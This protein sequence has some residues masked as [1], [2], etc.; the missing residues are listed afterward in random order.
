MMVS[1]RMSLKSARRAGF[2]LIELLVV[3]SIIAILVALLLPAVQAA[4]EAARSTQCKNNLRQFGIGLHAF[5]SKENTGRLCSGAWDGGRDGAL[6][7]YGWVADIIQVKAG[8][9][10]NMRCP[11]NP[12]LTTE[13]INDALA[14]DTS[15]SSTRPSARKDVFGKFSIIYENAT[16]DAAGVLIRSAAIKDMFE[17]GYNTNYAAGWHLVRSAPRLVTV[18]TG[19]TAVPVFVNYADSTGKYDG[20]AKAGFKEHTNTAGPLTQ[21]MMD[22]SNV[23]SS[24]IAILAD[25]ARGD[26]KEAVL[27][28]AIGTGEFQAGIP[29]AEAFNDGPSFWD[30]ATSKIKT[31][32]TNETVTNLSP[33][34][35]PNVGMN[36]SSAGFNWGQ[37]YEPISPAVVGVQP[38]FA[39]AACVAGSGMYLQDTRDWF[40]V[41]NGTC[42]LLMADGSVKQLQDRNNDGY[43]NPGF[44]VTTSSG[45]GITELK[46]QA[47]YI[48]GT[49]EINSFEVFTGVFLN[50]GANPKLSFE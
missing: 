33:R 46:Q 4:R 15:N 2:T 25:A 50:S 12:C 30:P 11:T 43:L 14:V 3:I 10:A 6:D 36:T 37:F 23:P 39:N 17:A 19:T 7:V 22:A 45:I 47:G 24:N 35:Y 49:V 41:H 21:R 13:K 42:N 38:V 9:P 44:P 40:A 8:Q 32:T 16:T 34:T 48:D 28:Y 29:L 1:K 27:A 20:N 5:S 26:A 31:A 18:N